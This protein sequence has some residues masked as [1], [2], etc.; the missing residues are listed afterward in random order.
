MVNKYPNTESVSVL[1]ILY[2]P[3]IIGS[4]LAILVSIALHQS[5]LDGQK[6]TCIYK[7]FGGM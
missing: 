5:P 1:F 2:W 7:G 3:N 6:F 4:P